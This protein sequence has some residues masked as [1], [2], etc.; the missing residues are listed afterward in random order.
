MNE[1]RRRVHKSLKSFKT[2]AILLKKN[3][4]EH[5][6]H[7]LWNFVAKLCG[8]SIG[9]NQEGYHGFTILKDTTHGALVVL[10]HLDLFSSY[11]DWYYR[12]LWYK[13]TKRNGFSG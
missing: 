9:L 6:L 11:V 4:F 2:A 7:K 5:K 13:Y 12:S 10:Y 8:G 3:L 1:W